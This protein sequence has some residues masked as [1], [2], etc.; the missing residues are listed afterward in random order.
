M[1]NEKIFIFL[2]LV[3]LA[4]LVLFRRDVMANAAPTPNEGSGVR[5]SDPENIYDSVIG[6]SIMP[7]RR[8]A[9][10]YLSFNRNI[11]GFAPPFDNFLPSLS[12]GMIG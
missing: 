2:A 5:G 10:S 3:A 7:P 8:D 11:W 1:E 12:D 9:V 6:A 4:A